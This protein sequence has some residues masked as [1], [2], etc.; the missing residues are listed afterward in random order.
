MVSIGL[1][2]DSGGA[3]GFT[4]SNMNSADRSYTYPL[5]KRYLVMSQYRNEGGTHNRNIVPENFFSHF[6]GIMYYMECQTKNKL[7]S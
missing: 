2:D 3:S 6:N 7:A 1:P 4:A 5:K